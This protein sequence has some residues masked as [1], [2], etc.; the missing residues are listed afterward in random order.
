MV[1]YEATIVME[2]YISKDSRGV[3]LLGH[4]LPKEPKSV[5]QLLS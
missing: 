3:V 5:T 1:Y 4:P 2:P